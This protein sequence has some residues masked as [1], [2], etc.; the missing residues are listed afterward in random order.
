MSLD[1]TRRD[2]WHRGSEEVAGPA[3]EASSVLWSNILRLGISHSLEAE[4]ALPVAWM[5]AEDPAGRVTRTSIGD[6]PTLLTWSHRRSDWTMG[7]TG[8]V[9]WPVGEL[10]TEGLPATATFSTGTVDP[11]IGAY[12]LGPLLGDWG[13]HVSSSTRWV[14]S[15]QDD[16]SRLGSSF[17]TSLGVNRT[18]GPRFVGQVLVT[19]F[20]RQT[21]TGNAMED[22]GGDWMYAQ[23]QVLANVFTRPDQSLQ[24]MVGARIP[25]LQNVRGT[26]LVESPSLSFGL[27]YT[28]NR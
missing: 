2:T 26:Q 1:S 17:S 25:M 12:L 3:K 10:G 21:D 19:H 4:V 18:I 7:V 14:V 23:P 15:D 11:T 27:A 24:A 16:G 9:Y 13:W 28:R 5:D 20:H 22:S 6:V 8:G